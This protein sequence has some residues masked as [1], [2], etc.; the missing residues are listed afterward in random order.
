MLDRLASI[1]QPS[2]DFSTLPPILRV[3]LLTDG[4]VTH[5]LAAYFAEDIQVRCLSQVQVGAGEKVAPRGVKLSGT[6]VRPTEVS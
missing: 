5:S 1:I 2:I 4:T 3:L 6:A